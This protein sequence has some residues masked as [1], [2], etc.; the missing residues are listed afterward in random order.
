MK[1]R[2]Q[3]SESKK[4]LP[5]FL[6][7]NYS[8]EKQLLACTC[9]WRISQCRSVMGVPCVSWFTTITPPCFQRA[10]STPG[11]RWRTRRRWRV[12][13]VVCPTAPP[14]CQVCSYTH[15]YIYSLTCLSSFQLFVNLLVFWSK[16]AS[17]FHRSCLI[18]LSDI[19]LPFGNLIWISIL[20]VWFLIHA[21]LIYDSCTFTIFFI[22]ISKYLYLCQNV[23]LSGRNVVR[24]TIYCN[25]HVLHI[26]STNFVKQFQLIKMFTMTFWK[27]KGKISKF[28]TRR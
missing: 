27:M 9:R 2:F 13:T 19:S 15:Y 11:P 21:Y 18:S 12:W 16:L 3:P 7:I 25:I 26:F 22:N 4:V 20:Y 8:S 10:W 28:C 6:N 14:P 5:Y 24:Y 17:T 1:I 23:T